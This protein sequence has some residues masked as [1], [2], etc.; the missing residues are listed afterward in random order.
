MGLVAGGQLLTGKLRQTSYADQ[1]AIAGPVFFTTGDFMAAEGTAQ[2]VERV[3]R[4]MWI[5][6]NLS[7]LKKIKKMKKDVDKLENVC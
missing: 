3:K 1:A 5:T 6:Q 4:G 7:L 2:D